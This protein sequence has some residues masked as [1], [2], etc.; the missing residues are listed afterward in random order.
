MKTSIHIHILKKSFENVRL[1]YQRKGKTLKKSSNRI[2]P[3]K[4]DQLIALSDLLRLMGDPSR[5]KIIIAC[6]KKPICVTDICDNTDLSQSLVSH[7]LRLLRAT[8]LL[9]AKRDG[10]QIFYSVNGEVVRCILIDLIE[11]ISKSE[12]VENL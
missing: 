10:R 11:H 3:I 9:K 12:K 2:P 4:E 8:S 5:L 7:H 1:K 6:M